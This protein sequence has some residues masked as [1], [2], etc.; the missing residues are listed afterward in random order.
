MFSVQLIS[1]DNYAQQHEKL[2]RYGMNYKKMQLM[3]QKQ[4]FVINFV[5]NLN[6]NQIMFIN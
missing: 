1:I 2:K 4:E 3:I 6:K 5:N